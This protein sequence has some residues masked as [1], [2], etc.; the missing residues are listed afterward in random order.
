MRSAHGRKPTNISLPAE[1]VAE[2]RELGVNLS[3]EL[4]AH[5]E[6]IVA[7]RRAEQWRIDNQKAFD[8]YAKYF[9]QNGVWNEDERDW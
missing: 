3:R 8:S 1:L 7:Q 9:E 4:E 5:L 6:R 2:A